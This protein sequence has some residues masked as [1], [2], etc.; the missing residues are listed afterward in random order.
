MAICG[1]CGAW[2][3]PPALERGE[4]GGLR[5]VCPACGYREPFVQRPLWWISGSPGAGKSAL[6][7]LLRERLPGWVVFEGEAID[8]WRFEGEPGEYGSLHNQWLK[9][10]RE[11][12]ANGVPVVVLATALPEQLDACTMHNRFSAPHS[13]PSSCQI[14]DFPVRLPEQPQYLL[15]DGLEPEYL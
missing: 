12:T 7:P 3:E 2:A 6:T 10:A 11:I 14:V 4:D 8:Y 5:S 13:A 15:V 1:R 9:V